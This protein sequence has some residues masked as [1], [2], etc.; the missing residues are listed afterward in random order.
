MKVVVWEN[1]ASQYC[2]HRQARVFSGQRIEL[3][4]MLTP[5][6]SPLNA[7]QYSKME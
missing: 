3:S 4:F 6:S 7:L 2:K 5:S 1:D